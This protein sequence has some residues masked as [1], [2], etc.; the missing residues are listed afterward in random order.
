MWA[1]YHGLTLAWNRG[2]RNI[3][4]YS[5]S[6]TAVGL[7]LHGYNQAHPCYAFVSA[8]QRVFQGQGSV[9]WNHS[10]R[11]ANQVVDVLARFGLSLQNQIR[12]FDFVPP[13]ISTALLADASC[14]SFPRGF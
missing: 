10:L 14:V 9:S 1:I 11:E 7:L 6:L 5:D 8:I 3:K 4:V 12:V 2:F 13:F